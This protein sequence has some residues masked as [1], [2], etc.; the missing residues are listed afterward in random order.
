MAS[1]TRHPRARAA[2]GARVAGLLGIAPAA[3]LFAGLSNAGVITVG[4]ML[5][6]AKGVVQTG[7]VVAD[8]LARCWPPRRPRSR[9][10]AGSIAPVGV[11]SALMNTTPIVAML[12]PATK[13]AG[14]DPRHP[15]P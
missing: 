12:I 1:G 7:V 5:V 3:E 2:R 14:A 10:C 8:D 6:I 15:G 11:A 9:R 13:A 4:G